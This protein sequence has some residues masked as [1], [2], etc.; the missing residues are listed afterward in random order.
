M[1]RILVEP[2]YLRNLSAQWQQLATDLRA[3]SGRL[4]GAFYG[5]DWEVRQSASVE[6]DWQSARG[7]AEMLAGRAEELARYLSQKAQAF[8]EADYAGSTAVGQVA[9]AFVAAQQQWRDWWQKVQPALSFPG[10]I[11]RRLLQLGGELVQ[12]P[13]TWVAGALGGAGALVG[14]LIGHR[15]LQPMPAGWE[16]RLQQAA[17]RTGVALDNTPLSTA[18]DAVH[19]LEPADPAAYDPQVGCVVYAKARRP[20]LAVRDAPIPGAADYVP[21]YEKKGMVARV[22]ATAPDL[23]QMVKPGYA[24]VWERNHPELKGT[25]GAGYGHVAIIEEVYPDHVVIS[26]AGWGTQYRRELTREQ[27]AAL[28]LIL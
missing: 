8:E 20:D 16:E 6:G 19:H 11:V 2:D 26:Q 3:T 12:G 23:R 7:R 15:L 22:S 28:A 9:G 25:P 24:A 10:A 1:A 4:S 17:G 13:L 14:L 21:Y 27:L 18:K 5:L